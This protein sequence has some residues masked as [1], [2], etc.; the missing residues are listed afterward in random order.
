[1]SYKGFHGKTAPEFSKFTVFD[2]L[3]LFDENCTLYLKP[4]PYTRET[5]DL[6]HTGAL[7]YSTL[8]LKVT[9]IS[10]GEDE[11]GP[12]IEIECW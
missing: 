8:Y 2:L 6:V 11:H 3:M 7:P 10:G 1:M 5:I 9:K 4:T 12:Y